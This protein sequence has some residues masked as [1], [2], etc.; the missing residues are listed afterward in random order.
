MVPTESAL[1]FKKGSKTFFTS[2]IFFPKSTREEITILYGFVRKA[3][4]LVDQIPQ[5]KKGF[6]AFVTEYRSAL[7]G[8]RGSDPVI[9][10]FVS[11]AKK[12]NFPL[13]WTESFLEAMEGDLSIKPY[14]TIQDTE[15][16][17]YGSA[18]VIGLFVS[19]ILDL[20]KE[21]YTTAQLLGK[22]FSF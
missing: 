18:D 22:V 12:K 9:R 7:K 17:I 14:R 19:K 10:A 1:L 6:Y 4:D 5:D 8:K 2:S 3:D 16:Y 21:A 20:P 11:L 15:R 13:E